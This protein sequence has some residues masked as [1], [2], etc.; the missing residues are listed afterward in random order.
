MKKAPCLEKGIGAF[1]FR[2]V[3]KL[4]C[5]EFSVYRQPSTAPH[6]Q[7]MLGYAGRAGK[8]R[9]ITRSG[10]VPVSTLEHLLHWPIYACI[11]G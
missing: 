3:L 4:N 8:A 10:S 7:F 11:S 5:I 6:I 2:E 1:L 9:R